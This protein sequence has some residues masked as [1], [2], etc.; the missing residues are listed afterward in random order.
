M[1]EPS[2]EWWPDMVSTH[3]AL[4]PQPRS[5]PVGGLGRLTFASWFWCAFAF[6]LHALLLAWCVEVMNRGP[7]EPRNPRPG[8]PPRE[9]YLFERMAPIVAPVGLL[10]STVLVAM[11]FYRLLQALR[12]I[13]IAYVRPFP[14]GSA[15]LGA[16]I[17]VARGRGKVVHRDSD[18]TIGVRDHPGYMKTLGWTR[19]KGK[20]ISHLWT[21]STGD[22]APHHWG[23][24]FGKNKGA[25][26]RLLAV[27][28]SL[29]PLTADSLE[30]SD[31]AR[32]LARR[33]K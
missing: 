11:T 19:N 26:K 1:P 7:W 3:K 13:A 16:P 10:L 22:G 25:D 33:T 18:F 29:P 2:R 21:V 6:P 14:D 31:A 17:E 9:P 20:A 4:A 24:P 28:R 30:T 5:I 32:M 15:L 8:Y 23:A 12:V 27:L